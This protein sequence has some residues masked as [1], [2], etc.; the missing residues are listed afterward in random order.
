MTFYNTTNESGDVL[1]QFKRK[2]R[3]QDIRVLDFFLANPKSLVTP[4]DVWASL[5]RA[6]VL[7]SI[8]RSVTNLT[9][10]GLLIKTDLRAEGVYGRP[11]HLWKL[12]PE[13][14]KQKEQQMDLPLGERQ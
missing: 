7:T 9:V 11:C 2:A 6:D 10:E 3:S 12:N 13:V 14:M 8:R 1:A 5:L 4:C